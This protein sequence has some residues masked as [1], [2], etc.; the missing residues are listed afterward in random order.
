MNQQVSFLEVV[1]F[2]G[3]YWIKIPYRFAIIIAGATIGIALET[4]IP[5]LSSDLFTA[6]EGYANG[7]ADFDS[8]WW[9]GATLIGLFAAVS[10]IQQGYFRVWMYFASEV[11]H[12]IVYDAFRRVQRFS[13]DWHANSFAGST[14]RKISRG[15]WAYDEY[16]DTVVMDLGPGA[17]LLIGMA[18]TMYMRNPVLGIYFA[19]S[20]VIFLA[21]SITMSLL[22]VAPANRLSNEADTELGGALADAVTCNVVVKSFGSEAREDAALYDVTGRWRI[23]AR[24]SWMRSMDAGAMQSVMILTL[25]GGL[26]L[27]VLS[28]VPSGEMGAADIIFVLTAYFVVNGYLRNIGWQVRNLQKSVNELDDL[29]QFSK[30]EPQVADVEGAKDFVP[31]AG[32]IIVRDVKFKYDNQPDALYEDLDVNITPGEKIALVGESGSGKSTFVKLIQRLYDVDEGEVIIDGQDISVVTQESL[33]KEISLVPQE[34]ILFHRTLYENICYG[35]PEATEEEVIE[36][37]KRAHAH[38]FISQLT[39]GYQTLVG[40]RG[41]KLSGGER[42]RVAIAR[43][44]LADAPILILDE[45]TSSLDSITEHLIQE[46]IAN[47]I[48]GRTAILIAHRL[49]T[50]RQVGRILV[51]DRG[52]IVEEGTHRELMA[53]TDGTYRGL[54]EMQTLGFIDD[55]GDDDRQDEE[56]ASTAAD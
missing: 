4:R 48:E 7:T 43:A 6:F 2:V 39:D 10:I 26:L 36:A 45:A 34:P 54:Y 46:G 40:E 38:D 5:V 11:M 21:V 29:V 19:V 25:L 13:S 8:A 35:K 42:Q 15:M 14:V 52:R 17:G 16:A 30:L 56:I 53:K 12:N 24:R 23:R 22:Y 28:M 9:A 37:A 47:L 51:F 33:R 1:R 50:I 32:S 20:V 55:T 18:F 49:S 3:R 31:G 27:I 44:I 41:I